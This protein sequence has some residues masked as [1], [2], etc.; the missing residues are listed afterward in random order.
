MNDLPA[1]RARQMVDNDTDSKAAYYLGNLQY[2]L[3]A[4]ATDL[5]GFDY[6]TVNESGTAMTLEA[7]DTAV[8]KLTKLAEKLG[9]K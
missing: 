1:A 7:I 3:V 5:A 2:M 9:K 8:S 4:D 6:S